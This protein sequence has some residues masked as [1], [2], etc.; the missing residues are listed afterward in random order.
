MKFIS[1]SNTGAEKS[2][3]N[4]NL[5][6]NKM[7]EF[8]KYT[9]NLRRDGDKIYSYSTHVAT[10]T[11]GFLHILG[12]WSTTTSKHVNY[13]AKELGLKRAYS[14]SDLLPEDR[15]NACI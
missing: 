2:K 13:A 11:N 7:T 5:K 14:I 1:N 12:W 15:E 8:A 6:Q 4:I 10:I 3:N 9:K